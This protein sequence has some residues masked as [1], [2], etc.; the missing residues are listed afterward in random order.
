MLLHRSDRA[1]A[2]G[3]AF[4]LTTIF[5]SGCLGCSEAKEPL[6]AGIIGAD[7][8]HAVAFTKIFNNPKV[9][10]PLAGVRVVAVYPGGSA[11]IPSS[12]ER[13]EEYTGQL[14]KMG[15]EACGSI[16]E[17]I[18][19]VDVVLLESVDG[20][21]HLE[22]VRPVIEAGKPVFIDKPVAASLVD[23]IRIYRLAKQR[24]VPIFSASALRFAR[25]FQ[26]MRTNPPGGKVVGCTAF[27]PCHLEPHHPDLFW[28]GVHGVETLYTIMGPGCE[29]VTRFR[30]PREEVVVGQWGDGRIGT[31]RGLHDGLN[32]GAVVFGSRGVRYSDR[33]EG[34]APLVVE[35]AQFFSSGKP[36]VSAEETLEMF[37]F[38]EA[39][40]ESKRQGGKPVSVREV[41]E[42]GEKEAGE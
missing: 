24:D 12:R 9:K 18:G 15:V 37:A 36:P 7:T 31:F 38:M 27:S 1:R 21:T 34:Y 20:R 40:D 39:A 41:M 32:Y 13:V 33:F 42:K 2:L 19:K 16:D 11:D 6:R 5:L 28:Y 4:F 22:Q 17:L 14:R 26:R 35:I 25:A 29:T 3:C 30:T 8:S 23:A 10:G